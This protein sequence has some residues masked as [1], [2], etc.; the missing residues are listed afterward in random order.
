MTRSLLAGLVTLGLVWSVGAQP[1]AAQKTK[2]KSIKKDRYHLTIDEIKDRPDL[3]NAYDAVRMLR[4]QWLR[5]VR[6][7]GTLGGGAFGAT[8]Y[9]PEPAK[10]AD[11]EAGGGKQDAN[12]QAGIQSRDN[13]FADAAAAGG[14]V[15]LYIDDVKQDRVE[16]LRNIRI[17]EIAEI[18]YLNGTMAS[19]RYGAGHEAGAI[20]LKT[21]R[22]I[23]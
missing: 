4:S 16:E 1:A 6:G 9:R 22:S 8:P 18:E 13:A 15:V 17:E 14:S 21:T 20:L 23:H 10:P 11:G 12:A 7:K 3:T 5:P 19:G 2:E